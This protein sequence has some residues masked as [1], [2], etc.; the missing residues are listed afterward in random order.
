MALFGK[1]KDDAS[2]SFVTK[3][4]ATSAQK[5]TTVLG[6][7]LTIKGIISGGDDIQLFGQHEGDINLKSGLMVGKTARIKGEITAE[8]ISVSGSVVGKLN[9]KTRLHLDQTSNVKGTID[10][11]KLSVKEGALFNGEMKMK[12]PPEA[13][14]TY[15]L[16][17]SSK[18]GGGQSG[19]KR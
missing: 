1:K 14:Q 2:S 6:K 13:S 3:K 17:P 16:P 12:V 10:T 7:N 18:Q 15:S 8:L 11:P 5:G 9:A 19:K 4:Q